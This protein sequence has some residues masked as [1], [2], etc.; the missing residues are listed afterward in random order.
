MIRSYTEFVPTWYLFIDTLK[1]LK[2]L[3]NEIKGLSWQTDFKIAALN[4]SMIVH[5]A[6]IVEGSMNSLLIDKLESSLEYKKA[7]SGNEKQIIRIFESLL[8]DV[9]KS[10]WEEISGR[11]SSI[12][13]GYKL[14]EVYEKEW[15]SIK[16][17]FEFRNLLAH[18]GVI[19]K[20]TKM[21]SDAKSIAELKEFEEEKQE[22]LTKENLF[23]FLSRKDLIDF[24]DFELFINWKMINSKTSDYFLVHAR[25]FLLKVYE[26]HLKSN[27]MSS[28][29][30][31]SI[32]YIKEEFTV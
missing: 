22:T 30:E 27:T 5:I 13:L 28:S 15:E 24:A 1:E 19:I 9:Q 21:V 14:K 32:N 29:L 8:F 11:L 6:A 7:K 26:N 16:Y 31:N 10:S 25:E 23:N 17:L 3:R 20:R 4:S 2:K 18:G 12:V